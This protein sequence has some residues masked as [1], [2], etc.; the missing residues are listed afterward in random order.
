MI[1]VYRY[2]EAAD[3]V[4]VLAMVDARSSMSPLTT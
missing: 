3:A 2:D 1:L 4:F